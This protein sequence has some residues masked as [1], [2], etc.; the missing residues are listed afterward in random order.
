MTDSPLRVLI[1]DDSPTVR[2]FLAGLIADAPDMMVVGEARNGREAIALAARLQPDIISMDIQMPRLDGLAATRHLM[3]HTPLPIVIVS[4]QLHSREDVDLAFLALQ[5][6]ALAV[7]ET[8][9]P[10]THPD[11][12]SRRDHFLNTLRSMAGVSLVRRWADTGPLPPSPDVLAHLAEEPETGPLVIAIG[13]SAG[14]PM[15]LHKILH[16]L[17]ARL[18]VPVVIVQHMAEGFVDG[19][20]RWLDGATPLHVMQARHGQIVGGGEV[21]IAP[22]DSHLTVRRLER[23]VQAILQP[24]RARQPYRPSVDVLFESVAAHFGPRA[25]GVLLTGMGTDG[26][27]GLLKMRQQGARTIAQ[28]EKSCLVYGMPG[29]AVAMGAAEQVV[30]I[31]HIAATLCDLLSVVPGGSGNV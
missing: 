8:P 27:K 14:G 3:Q 30:P 29:A 28:D 2:R 18:P 6:G 16:T 26:A 19:L 25:V 13:A 22:G 7:L 23:G 4:G 15:A 17:P 12:A 1:V 9:P 11:F 10:H 5:A 20:A 21:I 31:K 24:E